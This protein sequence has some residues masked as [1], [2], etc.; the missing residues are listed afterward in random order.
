[1][2]SKNSRTLGVPETDPEDYREGTAPN[3]AVNWPVFIASGGGI[4]AIALW[5]IIEPGQAET[6][7]TSAVGWISENL[8]WWYIGLA[9]AVVAFVV[10]VAASRFG[11]VRLGPDHSRPQYPWYS[12]A[13]M[14]F[15]AGIGVDLL[16]FAVAE[17]VT[18]Y[19]TPPAG[20]AETV[21]A[22][23]QAV[24][25]TIFHYGIT[26]WAMYAL[27]GMC[28]GYFAYRKGMPLTIR[29]VLYPII[30]KRVNGVAGHGVEVAAML[31]TVFGV[32]TSLGI[33]VVQLNYGLS[34]LFG[35]REGLAAQIALIAVA[36][37]VATW[38]AVS[39]VDKGIKR[40]SEFNVGLAIVLLGYILITGRTAFLMDA[41]IMNV[42]EYATSFLGL[43][44]DT[45]AFDGATEWLGLWTLFFWA[46]WVAWAPFVG[47]FLARISRGRSIRQFVLGTLTVPFMFVALWISIFGNSALEIV[48]GG[49]AAF[50]EAA[51]NTPERAFYQLIELYPAAPLVAGVASVVG[52]LL[53]ITSADSSALVMS[54][55]TSKVD[56]AHRDGPAWSRVFWAL[57]TG[58]L[59]IAMLVV[60]GI[61]TLQMATVIIGLPFSVVLV[62]AMVGLWRSLQDEKARASAREAGASALGIDRSFA[63]RLS[64]AVTYADDDDVRDFVIEVVQP[65]LADVGQMLH[66]MSGNG[67]GSDGVLLEVRDVDVV[68]AVD[69]QLVHELPEVELVVPLAG[70]DFIYGVQPISRPMPSYAFSMEPLSHVYYR[71]EVF[72]PTGSLG[73]DVLGA[74][75]EQ[76]TDDVLAR[77]E[78]HLEYL[79]LSGMQD[80]AARSGKLREFSKNVKNR[81]VDV[82]SRSTR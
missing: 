78:E 54:T 35:V 38:S 68:D 64:Y 25:L 2:I 66:T 29:A 6:V 3:S 15:A 76:L 22:A 21:A 47:L 72:G 79:E 74:T 52:L 14:L 12:W 69:D 51:M 32:A 10:I 40:L 9:T 62:L 7:L 53:Y 81:L 26:G 24:V 73:Y 4:L 28:F 17:P 42:G 70:G 46:W 56:A 16:F 82:R 58:I 31:G 1:M 55:F 48:M 57:T 65:T 5:A 45:Y 30:G 8:G 61:P 23:R 60:G 41:L 71:L 36:V 50:G 67:E 39:G 77:F 33:G 63:Q 13:S 75:R 18:Q 44:M 80:G 59:T 43:S 49:D 34:L 20:G 37:G 19:F 27:M 11:R